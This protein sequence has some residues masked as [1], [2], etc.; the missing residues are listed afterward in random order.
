MQSGNGY[1]SILFVSFGGPLG[2]DDVMPFLERVTHGKRVPRERLEEVAEHYHH[3][4]GISPITAQN[5]ELIEHVRKELNARGIDIPIYLGNRNWHPFLADTLQKMAGQGKKRALAFF[6]SMFSSYSGCRQYR[7]NIETARDQ[8]GPDAPQVEKVRFGFNHPGFIKAMS[9]R[10]LEAA[11]KLEAADSAE[12]Y[13]VFTAHSIPKSMAAGC[14][15][16]KQLLEAA[17]L[18]CEACRFSNY[19][20]AWQSRSGPPAVPWLEPDVNEVLKGLP[21]RGFKR[22]IVAPLGFISDNIEVLY[23]LDI[24]ARQTAEQAG[25]EMAR[26]FTVGIHPLFVSAV[27]DMLIERIIGQSARS[28]VGKL[29]AWHDACPP[30][31]CPISVLDGVP[32]GDQVAICGNSAVGT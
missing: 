1:D 3:F 30:D 14:A 24:E 23:D 17:R 21:A 26:A 12:T 7:E 29:P 19:E 27:A 25:L 8:V 5:L 10:V 18:I 6:T 32:R 4:G 2:P 9:D 15:Y 11:V 20:L 16:Q 13:V 31:C 28:A 22:A